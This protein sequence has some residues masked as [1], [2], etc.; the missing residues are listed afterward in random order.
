MNQVYAEGRADTEANNQQPIDKTARTVFEAGQLPLCL[1][2]AQCF[3]G[4]G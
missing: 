3:S 1:L 4:C 2:S